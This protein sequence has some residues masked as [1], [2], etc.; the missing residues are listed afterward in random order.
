MFSF[1]AGR[2]CASGEGIFEFVTKQ[3]SEIIQVIEAA[4]DAHKRDSVANGPCKGG[5]PNVS[6][7]ASLHSKGTGH[8]WSGQEG[9]KALDGGLPTHAYPIK[10]LSL[11]SGLQT[12]ATKGKAVKPTASC[13]LPNLMGSYM[14]L[15]NTHPRRDPQYGLRTLE[16]ARN[17]MV[18]PVK[19]VSETEYAD[20]FDS[21]SKAQGSC[22]QLN[23]EEA[24]SP[25]ASYGGQKALGLAAASLRPEH[26][27]DDPDSLSHMVYDEPQEVKW[28]AWKLQAMA[29]DPV[30]HEYPYN[31]SLDDYSVPKMSPAALGQPGRNGLVETVYDNTISRF[32]K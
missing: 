30:G 6:L 19:T 24:P 3:G 7:R 2:R 12:K 28:E 9:A 20:P 1:E 15:S 14:E 17:R 22:P 8:A 21:I 16:R 25:S 4:I 31:P 10:T 26:I 11:E 32:L 27:Y 13:P 5:S 29:E 23:S 18:P